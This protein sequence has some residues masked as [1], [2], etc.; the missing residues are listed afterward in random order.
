MW[1][2]A[3]AEYRAAAEKDPKMSD[4]LWAITRAEWAKNG[5]EVCEAMHEPLVNYIELQPDDALAHNL[6]G[7][8][9][10]EKRENYSGAERHFGKAVQLNPE[11]AKHDNVG[12]TLRR[13]QPRK[14]LGEFKGEA[15]RHEAATRI[16]AFF[17]G[18]AVRLRVRQ[19]KARNTIVKNM[20]G[21]HV[22][23]HVRRFRGSAISIQK[24][25]RASRCRRQVRATVENLVAARLQATWRRRR[26]RLLRRL[27]RRRGLGRECRGGRRGNALGGLVWRQP[28]WRGQLCAGG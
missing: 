7:R 4:A 10:L 9:L 16:Q 13:W 23:R 25:W 18:F 17:R 19:L 24:T 15:R 20:L 27:K 5:A 11:L 2:E 6:L 1:D 3:I 8:V 14:K 12:T 21:F 28:R 22:R 26:A